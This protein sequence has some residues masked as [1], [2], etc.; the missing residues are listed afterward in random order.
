MQRLA[1]LLTAL[2]LLLGTGL[3]HGLLT[4]RWQKS[5]ALEAA[6]VRLE[7]LPTEFGQWQSKPEV[8]SR[9]E[10]TLAR[11]EGAWV[12]RFS[13]RRTQQTIL[14]ILLC[15]RTS[16]MCAHRP[17]NCYPGA[18]YDLAGSPFNYTLRTT[19][20]AVLG[21]FWTGRFVKEESVGEQ[22]LRIFWSWLSDGK[23]QAPSW[24]RFHFA[25]KPYLYK[26][27][28]LRDAAYRPEKLNDD[29]AVDFMRQLIPALTRQLAPVEP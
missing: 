15:G 1:P 23:W 6:L 19:S 16:A 20:D 7:G 17:E 9:T 5:S 11:A 2:I 28:V 27:Y 10:L 3:V 22:Q 25:G 26:L 21:D 29:P 18:G 24:P 13:S 12:R 8:I 14:V 4:Q